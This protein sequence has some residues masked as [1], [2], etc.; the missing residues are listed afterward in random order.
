[1]IRLE[2]LIVIMRNYKTIKYYINK[3]ESRL[4]V[5]YSGKKCV[6][7]IH[8]DYLKGAVVGDGVPAII[9]KELGVELWRII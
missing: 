9:K 3:K 7:N 4:I 1:M 8:S 6:F 5:K 2:E